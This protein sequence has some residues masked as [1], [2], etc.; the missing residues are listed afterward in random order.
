MAR[1]SAQ[2]EAGL[3][4]LKEMNANLSPIVARFKGQSHFR[5]CDVNCG[6][7][8]ENSQV[9]VNTMETEM[10]AHMDV[11]RVILGKAARTLLPASPPNPARK[12]SPC[13]S[14][15][16]VRKTTTT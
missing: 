2:P 6:G 1:T 7:G 13:P 12:T 14:E 15:P 11:T 4:A 3:Y 5:A 8:A 16:H 10:D 9:S